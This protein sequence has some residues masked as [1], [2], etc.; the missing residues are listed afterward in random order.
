VDAYIAEL[1]AKIEDNQENDGDEDEFKA[2]LE[3]RTEAREQRDEAKEARKTRQSG[4]RGILQGFNRESIQIQAK[5]A[6]SDLDEGIEAALRARQEY[7]ADRRAMLE[8]SLPFAGIPNDKLEEQLEEA[9]Y[10]REELR[11]KLDQALA[12][13]GKPSAHARRFMAELQALDEGR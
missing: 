12:P 9:E 11:A 7:V 8:A 5:L 4:M 13:G 3:Q 2:L 1:D 10:Q 6:E